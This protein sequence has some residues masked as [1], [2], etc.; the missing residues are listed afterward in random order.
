MLIL[1][2][3]YQRDDAHWK[4]RVSV[5]FLLISVTPFW[6]FWSKQ[7]IKIV[8]KCV[9][10]VVAF[11]ATSEH[12]DFSRRRTALQILPFVDRSVVVDVLH[13]EAQRTSCVLDGNPLSAGSSARVANDSWS[14]NLSELTVVWIGTIMSSPSSPWYPARPKC[15]HSKSPFFNTT[16]CTQE[17]EH[18]YD[19]VRP[20]LQSLTVYNDRAQ[21]RLLLSY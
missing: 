15:M 1:Q 3:L 10:V 16:E 19:L 11:L 21:I 6:W 9:L 20:H 4:W 7:R 5:Q 18:Y 13:S 12:T 8:L 14:Q 2:E 17:R